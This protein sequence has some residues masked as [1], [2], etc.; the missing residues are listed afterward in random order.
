MTIATFDDIEEVVEKAKTIKSKS[1]S[2]IECKLKNKSLVYSRDENRL[3][4]VHNFSEMSYVSKSTPWC[5]GLNEDE[6]I[7]YSE[8][9]DIYVLCDYSEPDVS[10]YRKMCIMLSKSG[11]V[12]M[13][14]TTDN[15]HH[16]SNIDDYK[17]IITNHIPKEI[18][19]LLML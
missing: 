10:I 3:Y 7:I 1:R 9:Y 17:E 11:G 18:A 16:Y 5:I 4:K 12:D 15:V 2:Y 8:K 13:I 6:Y 14:V 19:D